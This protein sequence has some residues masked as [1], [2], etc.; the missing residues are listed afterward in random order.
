M[1]SYT[2]KFIK[3]LDVPVNDSTGALLVDAQVDVEVPPITVDQIGIS[4]LTSAAYVTE[5]TDWELALA[6]GTSRKMLI[7][8]AADD[9]IQ[10]AFDATGAGPHSLAKTE[11]WESSGFTV[12][13]GPIYV[14]SAAVGKTLIVTEG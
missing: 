5:S 11:K 4:A 12:Y 3:A 2:K 1:S 8:E 7:I 6:A 10:Y 13:R 9:G 14:K